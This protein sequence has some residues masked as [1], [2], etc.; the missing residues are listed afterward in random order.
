MKQIISDAWATEDQ[1]ENVSRSTTQQYITDDHTIY[2]YQH[3]G[4]QC[5]NILFDPQRLGRERGKFY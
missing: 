2:D 4:Y 5:G 1:T 3:E